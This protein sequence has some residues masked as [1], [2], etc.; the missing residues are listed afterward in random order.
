[1]N[2]KRK[3]IIIAALLMTSFFVKTAFASEVVTK[4]T[5]VI[6]YDIYA[7]DDKIGESVNSRKSGTKNS[8]R[9]LTSDSD[10]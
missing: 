4:V 1:M 9:T 3:K 10:T 8:I 6:K 5:T 2:L 7:D